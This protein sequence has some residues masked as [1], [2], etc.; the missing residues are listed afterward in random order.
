MPEN[1]GPVTA[2][3]CHIGKAEQ[4]REIMLKGI[5]ISHSNLGCGRVACDVISG[6]QGIH[7]ALKQT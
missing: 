5:L 2:T 7:V 4:E 1:V 3:S 6:E